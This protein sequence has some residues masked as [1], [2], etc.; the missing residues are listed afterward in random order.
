MT[1]SILNRAATIFAFYL[2]AMVREQQKSGHP[3]GAM[4]GAGLCKR[5]VF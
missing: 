4:G 3:G 1:T 2:L 5:S